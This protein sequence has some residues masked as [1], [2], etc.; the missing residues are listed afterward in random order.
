MT[1]A[2]ILWI[3]GA[4]LTVGGAMTVWLANKV[5]QLSVDNNIFSNRLTRVEMTLTMISETAAKLLHH[6][7]DRLGLDNYIDKYLDRNYELSMSE[8]RELLARFEGV[9]NDETKP[10]DVRLS[11]SLVFHICRHKLFLPPDKS[12]RMHESETKITK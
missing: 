8:W 2:T 4:V 10:R 6:D 11:A 3:F 12:L 7:D 9:M 5:T 1:E